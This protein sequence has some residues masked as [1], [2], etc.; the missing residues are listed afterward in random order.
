MVAAW[1]SVSELVSEEPCAVEPFLYGENT[2]IFA[3]LKKFSAL[4][5]KNHISYVFFL[6][7]VCSDQIAV[8]A[9]V[10][11]F[12]VV[13][14]AAAAAA[15]VENFLVKQNISLLI[16][17]KSVIYL[18]WA[19]SLSPLSEVVPPVAP[20]PDPAVAVAVA[21]AV[22]EDGVRLTCPL[23]RRSK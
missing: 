4:P 3:F 2:N 17:I 8:N 23:A 15:A 18:D 20:P 21:V 16:L 6:K 13:V 10:V 7:N 19:P 14:V 22:A 12:V 9:V 11:V 1:E 5:A